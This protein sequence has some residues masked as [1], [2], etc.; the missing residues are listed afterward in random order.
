MLAVFPCVLGLYDI[1]GLQSQ[2]SEVHNF[3][4]VLTIS[5]TTPKVEATPFVS[6]SVPVSVIPARVRDFKLHLTKTLINS[7]IG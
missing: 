4:V 6:V 7:F 1:Q 5:F 3:V 2:V